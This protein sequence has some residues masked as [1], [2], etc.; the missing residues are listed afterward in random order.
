[1]TIF[2]LNQADDGTV[3]L[4]HLFVP[5]CGRK[6]KDEAPILTVEKEGDKITLLVYGDINS[7]EPTHEIPLGGALLSKKVVEKEAALIPK[8]IEPRHET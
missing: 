2:K 4:A 6:E 1:M 7:S 8:M 3:R 5:G